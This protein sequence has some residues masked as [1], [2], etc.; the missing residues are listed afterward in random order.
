MFRS[1]FVSSLVSLVTL[2]AACTESPE[3]GAVEGEVGIPEV[4]GACPSRPDL[5]GNYTDDFAAAGLA[6]QKQVIQFN[7]NALFQRQARGA[8]FNPNS[9]EFDWTYAGVTNRSQR[10]E[11]LDAP[12]VR[13]YNV[14]QNDGTWDWSR[15][16]VEEYDARTYRPADGDQSFRAWLWRQAAQR[17]VIKFNPAAALQAEMRRDGFVPNSPEFN[18][19]IFNPANGGQM[20]V[21]V[22]RAERLDDSSKFRVYGW[23]NGRVTCSMFTAT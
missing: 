10:F 11:R 22:Q 14:A 19:S 7:P 21:P 5:A 23:V 20:V 4:L 13:I 15:V 8:G 6:Q 12:I 9:P 2:T 3:T 17:Q 16:A 18:I 1:F